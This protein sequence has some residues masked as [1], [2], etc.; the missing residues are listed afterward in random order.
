MH[1][2]TTIHLLGQLRIFSGVQ[3][4]LQFFH[5]SHSTYH[6]AP[7]I[8]DLIVGGLS[9]KFHV[10]SLFFTSFLANRSFAIFTNIDTMGVVGHGLSTAGHDRKTSVPG[11]R[12]CCPHHGR[13]PPA[14]FDQIHRGGGDLH[15]NSPGRFEGVVAATTWGNL[16]TV[17]RATTTNTV[18]TARR[19]TTMRRMAMDVDE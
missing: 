7:Y 5:S 14:R 19:G 3:L 17:R 12:A 1:K 4:S 10:T 8:V 13:L 2:T 11:H 18:A 15:N 6:T 16:V 9:P